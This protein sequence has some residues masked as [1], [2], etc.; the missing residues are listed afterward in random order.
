MGVGFFVACAE[1]RRA[2]RRQL[3]SGFVA[4]ARGAYSLGDDLGE[5]LAEGYDIDRRRV[6]AFSQESGSMLFPRVKRGCEIGFVRTLLVIGTAIFVMVFLTHGSEPC[7]A[8]FDNV[9]K[10]VSFRRKYFCS[11][12]RINQTYALKRRTV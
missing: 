5:S 4:L 11:A 10:L 9:R 2:R 6:H 1:G 3:F 7:A 12:M 8:A